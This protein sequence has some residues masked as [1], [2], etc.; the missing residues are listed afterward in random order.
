[1]K[2]AFVI[3]SVFF[4]IIFQSAAA[5][6][7]HRSRNAKTGP[8]NANVHGPVHSSPASSFHHEPEGDS[9]KNKSK[10]G[11][12]RNPVNRNPGLKN[13]SSENNAAAGWAHSEK[14][15]AASGNRPESPEMAD[16]DT[17]YKSKKTEINSE[18]PEKELHS[19]SE[20]ND[21]T[22]SA[23]IL[24]Y[25]GTRK[26]VSKENLFI[27]KVKT[28]NSAAGKTSVEIVFNQ[29]IN[30]R[31]FSPEK[32]K[33]NGS[34]VQGEVNFLF[35][36]NGSGVKIQLPQQNEGFRIELSDIE[37]FDGVV[38]DAAFDVEF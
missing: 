23:E 25:R 3:L 7:F 37:S 26:A 12:E 5:D 17:G 15:T 14:K 2:K 35:S 34:P 6:N 22:D 16:A 19:S 32:T 13:P 9:E 27:K 24:N 33:I 18:K 10:H 30:P 11:S 8:G 36:R 38:S 28:K 31:S 21:F 4:L 20:K 29:E 1:M